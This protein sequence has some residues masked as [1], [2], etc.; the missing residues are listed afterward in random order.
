MYTQINNYFKNLLPEITDDEWQAYQD[1]LTV[2]YLKKGDFLLKVDAVCNYVSFINKGMVRFYM[3]VEDKEICTGFYIENQYVA[4][5]ESFLTRKPTT[6]NIEAIEDTELLDLSYD[7]LQ[8]LYKTHPIFQIFGRL[9]AEYLF[10]FISQRTTSLL[11]LTPEQRYQK[12]IYNNS[13][14]LQRVPQYM[15][16]SYIGV[17]PEHLSRIRRKISSS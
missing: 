6:F 11:L 2:R 3:L 10:I 4:S 17:T 1:C 13:A 15:L 12:L 16:A 5:Y 7:Q 8:K 14:L 9:I